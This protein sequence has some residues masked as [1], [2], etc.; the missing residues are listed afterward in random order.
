MTPQTHDKL[1]SVTAKYEELTQLVSD[2][3]VML[4]AGDLMAAGTDKPETWDAPASK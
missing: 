1:K 4:G 3:K 2:P